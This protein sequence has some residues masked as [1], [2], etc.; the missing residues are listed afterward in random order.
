M[1]DDPCCEAIHHLKVTCPHT[2]LALGREA[3]LVGHVMAGVVFMSRHTWPAQLKVAGLLPPVG[4]KCLEHMPPRRERV[5]TKRH[6]DRSIDCHALATPTVCINVQQLPALA[7]SNR[8]RRL[9]A[10]LRN[11]LVGQSNQLRVLS[12][13]AHVRLTVV[14]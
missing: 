8:K 11:K 12:G 4:R 3:V 14:N 2:L 13:G 5:G 7:N 10:W 6:H 9:P 1:S